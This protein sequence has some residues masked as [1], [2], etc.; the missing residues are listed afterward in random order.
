MRIRT[1]IPLVLLASLRCEKPDDVVP[2]YPTYKHERPAWSN[3]GLTIAFRAEIIGV[4]GMYAVDSSGQN[5]RLVHRGDAIGFSWSPD[6]KWIVF[7][8]TSNLYKIKSNGDSMSQITSTIQDLRPAWSRD[9]KRVAFF[10]KPPVGSGSNPSDGG[11]YVIRLD[12]M[13]VTRIDP[14]GNFPSWDQLNRVVTI[15]WNYIPFDVRFENYLTAFQ[16]DSAGSA[17][18]SSFSS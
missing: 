3:D 6:S 15:S 17:L 14:Q 13:L 9:G 2:E 1:L 16:V 11:V 8:Q 10:R 5:L 4:L 12:S 7:S 18:L